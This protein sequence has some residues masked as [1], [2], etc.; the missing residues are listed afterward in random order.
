MGDLGKNYDAISG[1]EQILAKSALLNLFAVLID[2][3]DPIDLVPWFS[4][5]RKI[6]L[7][8]EQFYR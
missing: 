8:Q 3:Q 4:Y 7:D 2:E 5:V 6:C 1:N